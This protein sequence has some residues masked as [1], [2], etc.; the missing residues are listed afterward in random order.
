MVITPMETLKY[1]KS[2]LGHPYVPIELDDTTIMNEIILGEA[3]RTYSTYYPYVEERLVSA[4]MYPEEWMST[5]PD[6][7]PPN[8]SPNRVSESNIIRIPDED[9][10]RLVKI[11]SGVQELNFTQIDKHLYKIHYDIRNRLSGNTTVLKMHK[12][13]RKDFTTFTLEDFNRFNRLALILTAKR[14]L[15]I[16]QYNNNIS[17]PIGE[18][19]T[20]VETVQRIVDTWQEFYEKELDNVRSFSKRTIL[21]IV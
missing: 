21:K 17:T 16:R 5:N 9:L 13:H 7:A 18:I 19:Q 15:P 3:L 8:H 10:I 11:V 1:I 14:L 2:E 4:D 12:M 6:T 20:D